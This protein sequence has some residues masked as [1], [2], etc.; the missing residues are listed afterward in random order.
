[1]PRYPDFPVA[2][3][4]ASN[5][6]R[7]LIRLRYSL[8]IAFSA[9]VFAVGAAALPA[10]R[11]FPVVMPAGW[12][13]P[14][15]VTLL[16]A[17]VVVNLLV[18]AVAASAGAITGRVEHG[19]AIPDEVR[20]GGHGG[21][22]R[23]SAGL[24]R[25]AAIVIV[26]GLVIVES[27]AH[28]G[29]RSGWWATGLPRTE[30]EAVTAD[31][32][33]FWL[34]GTPQM[35]DSRFFVT[36]V[37][38]LS[39]DGRLNEIDDWLRSGRTGYAVLVALVARVL[40]PLGG[41]YSAVIFVGFVFWALAALTMHDLARR[42]TGSEWAAI[43][44]A[45]FTA[46]GIGFTFSIGQMM[47]NAAAYGAQ[48][49]VLWLIERLRV[50]SAAGRLRDLCIS[51][52]MAA[53]AS[54]LNSQTPFFLLF[55]FLWRVGRTEL[56]RLL[57]WAIVLYGCG[58]LWKRGLD[59][60]GAGFG[61][62]AGTTAVEA[63]FVCVGA[64]LAVA[65]AARWRRESERLTA[66]FALVSAAAVCVAVVAAPD[67]VNSVLSSTAS[68]LNLPEYILGR[69]RVPGD[70][71]TAGEVD[72]LASIEAFR[73]ALFD[74]DVLGAF[75]LPLLPLAA[76]GMIGLRR[77]WVE[78]SVAVVVA[79]GL[80]AFAMDAVTGSLHPRLAFHAYPA[81]YLTAANGVMNAFRATRWILTGLSRSSPAGP[82]GGVVLPAAL[83]G[84]LV[85]WALVPSHASL[86]G[87]WTY[88]YFYG[89][90]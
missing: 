11:Q 10:Y 12:L 25:R 27:L 9:I 7:S 35:E 55:P 20:T 15:L 53:A 16:L 47:P 80:V 44:A 38:A 24:A 5:P 89:A 76:L 22:A 68:S 69:I 75:P 45:V 41:V 31:G 37:A 70:L 88:A 14:Y 1:V 87:D 46:T 72:V 64:T 60:G 2:P 6:V 32:N 61:Q 82:R 54:T 13:S 85:L 57:I 33:G 56:H 34:D 90:S 59:V 26:L 65:V 73:A 52:A 81:I 29:E 62:G 17:V 36:A 18:A 21:L 74:R 40:A 48:A 23:P 58:M 66:A 43:L 19:T 63:A 49:I 50:F 71:Q 84:A 30:R 79:A 77:R 4:L 3:Q 67:R 83:A 51:A 78:W 42:A 8:A 39:V 28:S 86:V